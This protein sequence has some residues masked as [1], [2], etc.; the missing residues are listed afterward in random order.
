[1]SVLTFS[2]SLPPS[3]SSAPQ[4][5]QRPSFSSR[6]TSDR[7]EENSRRPS[8]SV[9]TKKLSKPRRS[10][11]KEEGLDDLSTSVHSVPVPESQ[12][13]LE[14]ILAKERQLSRKRQGRSLDRTDE[15]E[16]DGDS[17]H[18]SLLSEG[19]EKENTRENHQAHKKSGS[20][21]WKFGFGQRKR[22]MIKSSA[23]APPGSF[24]SLPRVAMLVF[25]IAVVVPG[26]RYT[27]NV[28]GGKSQ[29]VM[30]GA[31]AGVIGRKPELVENASTIA[32]R[33][34]TPTD[35]CTRWAHQCKLDS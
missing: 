14:D 29:V 27:T 34:N 12:E 33:A 17:I 18:D 9:A 15:R 2:H 35:V 11:F 3:S 10:A 21:A 20:A 7:L 31:D 24:S 28:D 4:R 13:K 5:T 1:M 26:F 23:T 6:K 32:G 22:P 16:D 8:T 25:L 19:S 30:G